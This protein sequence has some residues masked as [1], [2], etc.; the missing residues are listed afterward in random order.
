MKMQPA[1]PSRLFGNL[2]TGIPNT[3]PNLGYLPWRGGGPRSTWPGTVG[4]EAGA[5]GPVP[6]EFPDL[7][8]IL[9]WDRKVRTPPTRPG[10]VVHLRREVHVELGH[11]GRV[12]QPGRE[13]HVNSSGLDEF[14]SW[15]GKST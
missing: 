7:G 8:R 5:T 13:V 6:G 15:V 4:E 10:R 1:R 14:C 2:G 3:P 12:L 11:S 9:P